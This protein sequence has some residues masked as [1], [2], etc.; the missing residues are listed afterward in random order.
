MMDQI[1]NY[2]SEILV[3]VPSK[4]CHNV[5]ILSTCTHF[6]CTEHKMFC[7]SK[8]RKGEV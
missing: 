1:L 5:S 8:H 3:I 4:L 6:Y 7:L 2:V